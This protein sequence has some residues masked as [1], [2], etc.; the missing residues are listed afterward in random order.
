MRTERTGSTEYNQVILESSKGSQSSKGS[1]SRSGK[2]IGTSIKKDSQS[3]N[4]VV[5]RK[6]TERV[7]IGCAISFKVPIIGRYPTNLNSTC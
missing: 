4:S 3:S 7:N 6:S 2:D 5:A 1:S